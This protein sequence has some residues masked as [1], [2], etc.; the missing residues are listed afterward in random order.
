MVSSSESAS[1]SFA[2]VLGSSEEP[3]ERQCL[4][5]SRS[6]VAELDHCEARIA[7]MHETGMK[8]LEASWQ[9]QSEK[10]DLIFQ[11]LCK[12]QSKQAELE[13]S[14]NFLQMVASN[15]S[16]I[17]KI[18]TCE[19]AL[20]AMGVVPGL[21]IG[22][23]AEL[24]GLADAIKDATPETQTPRSAS[25]SS[26]EETQ[27]SMPAS[28]LSSSSQDK[29]SLDVWQAS[30]SDCLEVV[31]NN[32]RSM[33]Y[34][35]GECCAGGSVRTPSECGS[36]AQVYSQAI[37]AENVFPVPATG[38]FTS[39]KD[40]NSVRV[41]AA[42]DQRYLMLWRTAC[43][44]PEILS[45][46]EGSGLTDMANFIELYGSLS[47][48]PASPAQDWPTYYVNKYSD[49][50][51][52]VE[53]KPGFS[54]EHVAERLLSG[55]CGTWRKVKEAQVTKFE[56]TQY[57]FLGSFD[58]EDPEEVY[59]DISCIMSSVHFHN[60][61]TR[62]QAFRT[63]F[64]E[65]RG[66][67]E[68]QFATEGALAFDAYIHLLKTFAA[69]TP[70]HAITGFQATCVGLFCLQSGL[71]TLLSNRSV[72]ISLFEGFLRFCARYFS[73]GVMTA[74]TSNYRYCAMDL[75]CGGRWLPRTQACWESELYFMDVEDAL[76][77]QPEERF[78]VA[79]SLDPVGVALAANNL[80]AG[81]P[82]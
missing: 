45:G 21:Q 25:A 57:T 70:N 44:L 17:S 82:K 42:T 61:R 2:E 23:H 18:Y 26:H 24:E 75:S 48:Q 78:N 15:C 77:V 56:T 40:R 58:V 13:N 76:Q 50:D 38:A 62:Q 67:L 55:S 1:K 53:V 19:E 6:G 30:T 39:E 69:N 49:V 68:S 46:C 66:F 22:A 34:D 10:F 51:F 7:Y 79:H 32:T 54:P 20:I 71:Y 27:S 72:A 64:F 80:L 31:C 29:L 65:M 36:E 9:S 81:L 12:L 47:L 28:E 33:G 63:V 5:L 14:I 73:D 60:L 52:A 16:G 41:L 43:R 59:L 37:C 4:N 11:I 74:E 8:A 35:E 3:S